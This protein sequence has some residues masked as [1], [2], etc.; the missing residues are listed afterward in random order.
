MTE[1]KQNPNNFISWWSDFQGQR[2]FEPGVIVQTT[3]IIVT[4]AWKSWCAF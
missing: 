3:C 4:C 1:K 2:H